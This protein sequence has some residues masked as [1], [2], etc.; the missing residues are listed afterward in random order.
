MEETVSYAPASGAWSV[1][2][3]A[4]LYTGGSYHLTYTGNATATFRFSGSHVWVIADKNADHGKFSVSL[5]GNVTQTVDGH[6]DTY[7]PSNVLFESAVT[8]GQHILVLTNLDDKK[9]L[10]VDQFV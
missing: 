5:D 6:S 8:S 7:I 9:G 3:D 4:N 2:T 1:N 10:G